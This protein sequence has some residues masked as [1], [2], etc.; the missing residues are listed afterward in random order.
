MYAGI[1]M[2]LL[3]LYHVPLFRFNQEGLSRKD[4]A[5]R[6]Q[7]VQ[8]QQGGEVHLVLSSDD[9]WRISFQDPVGSRFNVAAHGGRTGDFKNLTDTQGGAGH[10]VCRLYGF[11]GG[12]KAVCDFPEGISLLDR[13]MLG[14][15]CFRIASF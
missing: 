13:I 10:S 8:S 15:T 6:G 1:L 2:R 9:K 4:G 11:R 3:A 5:S 14:G 12:P 7:P